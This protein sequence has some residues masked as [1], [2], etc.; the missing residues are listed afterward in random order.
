MHL[1]WKMNNYLQMT[2][3]VYNIVFNVLRILEKLSTARKQIRDFAH[4]LQQ[5]KR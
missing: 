4:F 3:L 5:Y 1:L 2:H